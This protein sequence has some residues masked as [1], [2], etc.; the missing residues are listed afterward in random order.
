MLGALLA[1]LLV[2]AAL[3]VAGIHLAF[4]A[5]RVVERG[6]PADLGLDYR[7]LRIPTARGRRLFAWL[8]EAD[9]TAPTVVVMHGWGANA[10]LMLPLAAPFRRAGY[11]VL[12][13]DAR[14]H[15]QSDADTFSS[16]PRFAEDVEAA[17]RWLEVDARGVPTPVILVGHSVGAGACL[18]AASR[19]RRVAAVIS[20]AAFGHPRWMMRRYLERLRVPP[21]L[22]PPINGYVQAVIGHRFDAIAPIETI[23]RIEAPVLLV[24]G[25]ADR[26]VPAAD[27]EALAGRGDRPLLRIPGAGHESVEQVEGHAPRLL[28]FLDEQGLG[29]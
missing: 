10:E 12:L 15:G 14:G 20:I 13:P 25:E 11:N 29:P 23:T 7:S 24:H 1:G 3:F 21:W 28:A 22:H 4:R 26:T 18:L 2:L 17:V 9:P 8:L 27:A 16:L 5:P 19:N 6:T